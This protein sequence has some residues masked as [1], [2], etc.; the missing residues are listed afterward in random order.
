MRTRTI[1]G[2]ALLV[3]EAGVGALGGLVTFGFTAEY[4][5][6]GA[7][8]TEAFAGSMEILLI[9]LVVAG[10]VGIVAAGVARSAVVTSLAVAV[11]VLMLLGTWLTAPMALDR[12]LEDQFASVPQCLDDE[13]TTGP[14]AEAAR[15]AQETF[16]SIDHVGWFGGGGSTGVGGCDRT[17]TLTGDMEDTDV[18][19][20][21]AEVL[22]ADGWSV[23]EEEPGGLRA[24]RDGTAFE[25]RGEG[26]GWTVWTGPT[27]GVAP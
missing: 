18:V 5:D 11:P 10:S 23:V 14:G 1:A 13:M 21:Y 24:E 17:M 20:H 9:G 19:G 8:R 2:T 6:I 4:G 3:V 26:S 27:R 16:D 7:S 25:V 22:E 12:K 15:E